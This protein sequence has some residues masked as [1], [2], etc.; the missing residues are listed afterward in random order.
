VTRRRRG[1]LGRAVARVVLVVVATVAALVGWLDRM[2]LPAFARDRVHAAI[3]HAGLDVDFT[4]LRLD[5]PNGIEA[6]DVRVFETPASRRPRIEAGIVRIGI[7]WLDLLRN[8][9]P[10][11]GLEIR[12]GTLL[13]G[14]DADATSGETITGI[15]ADLQ[16]RDGTLDVESMSGVW[17]SVSIR[18]LGRIVM[19]R[20]P[21]GRL[22]PPDFLPRPAAGRPGGPGPSDPARLPLAFPGGGRIEARIDVDAAAP[23][24]ASVTLRGEGGT[25]EWRGMPFDGW[26]LSIRL[27]RSA[28]ILDEAALQAGPER[29]ALSGTF[30]PSDTVAQVRIAGSV[31]SAHAASLPLPPQPDAIRSAAGIRTADP[32]RLDV[33]FGPGPLTSLVQRVRGRVTASRIELLGVWLESVDAA[34]E[35]NGPSLRLT[36]VDGVAG[37]GPMAGPVHLEGGLDLP[38]GDYRG[39]AATGFDPHALMPWLD[40]GQSVHVGALSFRSVPPRCSAE[41][42]G[43]IGDIRRLVLHGTLDATNLLYNGALLA[44]ASLRLQV[45]N[46]VMRMENVRATRPEGALT[47]WI[48]QDFRRRML[49]FDIDS[50]IDPSAAAR[51]CGPAPHRF[52]S[53]FRTEGPARIRAHGRAD[54]GERRDNDVVFDID[55]HAAGMGWLLLDRCSFQGRAVGRH[56]AVTGA[57]GA[58]YGGTFAGHATFDLPDGAEARTRYRVKGRIDDADFTAILRAVTDRIE[59][60]HEGRMSGLVDLS[61][62]IGAGQGRTATGSGSIHVEDGRLLEIPIFGGFS[63][64]IARVIPGVAFTSQSDFHADFRIAGGRAVTENAELQGD[65]LTMQARGAYGFDRSLDFVVE[66]KLLREGLVAEVVRLLT[67]PVTKL[68]E[69]DLNGSLTAPQWTPR[70]MPRDLVP[71]PGKGGAPGGE[72]I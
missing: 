24:H 19:A 10:L 48:E 47:G 29:V 63:R 49:R 41:I 30:S 14:P 18:A 59:Q 57:T 39:T 66:A 62:F 11:D 27:A 35:R 64:H 16:L 8:R 55:A 54:Y 52:V 22:R 1:R 65:L 69:Y 46:E 2:G 58:V 20:G 5:L 3:R 4:G 26:S 51:L 31:S 28:V 61:G 68:L 50:S 9:P 43:R 36:S 33:T 32:I 34:F 37:R 6:S 21:D 25:L 38:S 67:L 40:P 23:D 7:R 56:V 42:S 53:H 72:R 44:T 71:A 17:R 60:S 13:L 12:D 70:N 45:S 15:R